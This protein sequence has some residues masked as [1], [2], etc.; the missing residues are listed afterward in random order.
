MKTTFKFLAF[1]LLMAFALLFTVKNEGRSQSDLTMENISFMNSAI[2][3]G[4]TGNTGPGQ[5]EDCAGIGTGT[6]KICLCTN[7]KDCTES[8]CS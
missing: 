8:A 5:S 7:D 2:A 4:G 6:K 1:A 3:E